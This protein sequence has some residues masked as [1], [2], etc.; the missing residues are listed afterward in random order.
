MRWYTGEVLCY[1]QTRNL[2]PSNRN[3]KQVASSA[4][5]AWHRCYSSRRRSRSAYTLSTASD[6]ELAFA[7]QSV[8]RLTKPSVALARLAG[9]DVYSQ[10]GMPATVAT[11][12]HLVTSDGFRG[13]LFRF[14]LDPQ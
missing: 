7:L 11:L 12:H 14:R 8:P 10:S 6:C 5:R 4:E 9:A 1:H 13:A 2:K 3:S